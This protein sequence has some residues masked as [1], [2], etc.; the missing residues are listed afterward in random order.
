MTTLCWVLK[1]SATHSWLS[2]LRS[3]IERFTGRVILLPIGRTKPRKWSGVIGES[4]GQPNWRSKEGE[5]SIRRTAASAP[6]PGTNRIGSSFFP[7]DARS[8]RITGIAEHS[9]AG[10]RG[11]GAIGEIAGMPSALP[12]RIW[13]SPRSVMKQRKWPRTAVAAF[14]VFLVA[15][16]L[17][18]SP[19]DGQT[20][21]GILHRRFT[22]G[23]I[24]FYGYDGLDWK[25]VERHLPVEAGE[26]QT[27]NTFV[28]RDTRLIRNIVKAETGRP[29][30][31]VGW[32]CCDQSNRL[33]LYIG[34]SGASSRKM[35]FR[36]APTGN[37]HLNAYA[38]Q[39]YQ[40]DLA[41]LSQA[42]ARGDAGENDSRGYRLAD[43][44]AARRIELK[45]QAYAVSHGPELEKVLA[46]S[47]SPQQ[48]EA[49]ACLLGYA[50]RSQARID[51]LLQAS[52]DPDEGVRNNAVRS[53]WV[54]FVSHETPPSNLNISPVIGLLW[55][56]TWTDRN[57]AS[58]LL[59]SLT[60]NRNP[61]ILQKLRESA[62]PPLLEGA[63][64]DPNHARSFLLLLGRVAS[65]PKAK[66]QALISSGQGAQI[67]LAAEQKDNS[68]S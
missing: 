53:L 48:R 37:E 5:G 36:R 10:A 49:S 33:L 14:G 7:V 16:S 27:L 3:G 55:S 64:W 9:T 67:I 32:T 66:L 54:L 50:N 20:A 1:A 39:L 6:L 52:I 59:A 43:D 15:P 12:F 13:V 25:A 30:T 29:A 58:L 21:N 4:V 35:H 2:P 47:A 41:A 22:I 28:N 68:R 51:S 23:H 26:S 24:Y 8:G 63:R 65:I 38:L 19:S 18:A 56:G 42:L 46:D 57:K 40:D 17:L 44:P 31:D 60:R 45:M 61:K 11:M 62:M 34:L